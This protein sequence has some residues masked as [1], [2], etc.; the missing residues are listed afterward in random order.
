MEE[1]LRD[2]DTVEDLMEQ[3]KKLDRD[4]DGKIPNPEIK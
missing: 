4:K 3:L 2:V 1:K